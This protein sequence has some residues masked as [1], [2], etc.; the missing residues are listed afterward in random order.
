MMTPL[1]FVFFCGGKRPYNEYPLSDIEYFFEKYFSNE[2][3][4]V[5]GMCINKILTSLSLFLK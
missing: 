5:F 4:P 3:P 2:V 1:H